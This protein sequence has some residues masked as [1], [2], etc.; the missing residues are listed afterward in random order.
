MKKVF[1]RRGLNEHYVRDQR[2]EL[3]IA[4]LKTNTPTMCE[5]VKNMLG[6]EAKLVGL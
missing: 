4:Y 3:I 2:I 6:D 1:G 5:E